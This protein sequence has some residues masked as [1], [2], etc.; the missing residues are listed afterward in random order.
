MSS[1]RA[2]LA[3]GARGVPRSRPVINPVS[4]RRFWETRA[5]T[6]AWR[7]NL[8]AWLALAA[9]VFF[10]VGS[11]FAIALYALR[12]AQ[13][14]LTP[15]WLALA[16]AL[17]LAAVACA[18]RARRAFYSAAE[19]RVLLE[20]QL[21]LDTRLTAAAGGLV[22]WPAVPAPFPSVVRWQLRAPLG[23]LL[24]TAALLTLAVYAPVSRDGAGVHAAGPPPSLLTAES[25]LAALKEMKLADPPA[26]EQLAERARELARRPADE[27]YSHSAL[28]AAD[29]LR[30]QTSVA[31]ASL[32]RGLDAAASALRA[33]NSD[34]DMKSAAGRLAA[35]L[36]GL[37]DGALPANKDLL[38]NLPASAAD[39]KNLTAEQREQLAK[40]LAQAG[41]QAGGV[42]GAAGA[43]A[44]VAQPDPNSKPGEGQ[45]VGAGGEGGGGGTAPLS[46]A[47][48]PSD[49][50]DGLSQGINGD[51]FKR[52]SLGDKLGTTTGQHEKDPGKEIAPLSAGAVATPASGGEAVWVNRLTPAER[53]ALKNFFK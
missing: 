26:I 25:M 12:R 30:D 36:S 19:A 28:E 13:N 33:S 8:A 22:A 1:L 27:Q 10:F 53:A 15:A 41:A 32:A 2:L 51:A 44:R 24:T 42:A 35:A 29:A 47:S 34:T 46:L 3:K 18:W 5:T 43:G 38:A 17:G 48:L 45:G 11:G 6:L 40:Q 16:V 4:T 49:A 39:L 23:W 7:I 21:R 50:G 14:P 20:S 31:A 52:F 9:P 37:K